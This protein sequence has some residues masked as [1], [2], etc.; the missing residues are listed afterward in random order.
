VLFS[1]I[2]CSKFEW[3]SGSFFARS[4]PCFRQCLLST[5]HAEVTAT[6]LRRRCVTYSCCTSRRW[7][8]LVGCSVE[9]LAG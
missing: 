7:R 8:W 4:S 6:W 5:K 1:P 9:W 3:L 2:Y